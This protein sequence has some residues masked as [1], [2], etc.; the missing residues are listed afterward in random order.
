MRLLGSVVLLLVLLGSAPSQAQVKFPETY[1]AAPISGRVVDAATGQPLEGV[2]IVAQWVLQRATAGGD[3]Y[4]GRLQI[5][6]TV[7]DNEGRYRFPGWGPKPNPIE[8]NLPGLSFCC[9]FTNRDPQLSIFKPGYRPR[10]LYNQKP[11]KPEEPHRT[12]T[13]DGQA[14]PLDR[15]QGT[16]D[17]WARALG[18][19]QEDLWWGM[20][21]WQAFPRMILSVEEER[22]T[23][24]Q[25]TIHLRM[26]GLEGF[27]INRND[28]IREVGRLP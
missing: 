21:D 11:H 1:S 19:L 20:G 9:F 24:P 25:E 4:H 10:S 26:S 13:W 16:A 28:L 8:I 2:I 6:E 23:F 12:S 27:G 15:F 22:L 5:L 3:T 17:Q 18:F 7:T 14:I